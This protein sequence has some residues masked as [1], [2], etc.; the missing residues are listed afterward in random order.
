MYFLHVDMD[1]MENS[2]T[3]N[4]GYPNK[5]VMYNFSLLKLYIGISI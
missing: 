1:K 3:V 2:K 4:L 5:N